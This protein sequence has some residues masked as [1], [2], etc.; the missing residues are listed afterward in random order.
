MPI[1]GRKVSTSQYDESLF[2]PVSDNMVYSHDVGGVNYDVSTT[3]DKCAKSSGY[4]QWGS[5]IS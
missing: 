1:L 5:T 4:T 3:K 2:Q